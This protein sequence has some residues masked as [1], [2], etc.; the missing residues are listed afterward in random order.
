MKGIIL[1]Y[2]WLDGYETQNL[3][4]KIKVLHTSNLD[5]ELKDIPV[6]N[7]DGSSTRQ[8]PGGNSECLLSP[9]RLYN[10]QPNHIYV[11]CEVMNSDGSPHKSNTRAKLRELEDDCNESECWW[12]FEQEY[13]ITKDFVP[14]GFPK[15][16][17][18]KPQGLYYCGVGGNLPP[19][20]PGPWPGRVWDS[21][22]ST[23]LPL[24]SSWVTPARCRWVA[25][26]HSS[27]S[28]AQQHVYA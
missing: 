13:F 4:S 11:L 3:R 21:S 28:R 6:W 22:G 9:V 15:G 16:G 10:L 8:A 25:C 2:V 18:P 19:P 5:V 1:E 27:A 12:G 17:Y 20:P 23:V 7:F 24:Q 14:L 26:S